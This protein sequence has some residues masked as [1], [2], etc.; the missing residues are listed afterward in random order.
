VIAAP[1]ASLHP[2]PRFAAT[3]AARRL[4]RLEDERAIEALQRKFV[5]PPQRRRRL[6][7]VRRVVRIRRSGEGPA[8]D[9]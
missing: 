8:L 3:T 7:R 2:P 4:G 9:R 5:R 6:R 1:L